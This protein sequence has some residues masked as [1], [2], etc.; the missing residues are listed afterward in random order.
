MSHR[1]L[2]ARSLPDRRG[3][4]DTAFSFSGGPV[5]AFRRLLA[6]SLLSQLLDQEQHLALHHE[7]SWLC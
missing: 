7:G 5:I 3:Q 2:A 4:F 6:P 1:G